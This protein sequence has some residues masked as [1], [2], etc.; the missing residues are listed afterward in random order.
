MNFRSLRRLINRE[1]QG[2]KSKRP[3]VLP[4]VE[5]LESRL[6]PSATIFSNLQL[7][8]PPLPPG[9][10]GKASIEFDAHVSL[11]VPGQPPANFDLTLKSPDITITDGTGKGSLQ[12]QKT[13][14]LQ[15]SGG[16]GTGAADPIYMKYD[17]LDGESTDKVKG[18]IQLLDFHFGGRTTFT[19][20][21][22]GVA[23]YTIRR[24]VTIQPSDGGIPIIVFLDEQTG[25]SQTDNAND[26]Q[27]LQLP[28]QFN[29]VVPLSPPGSNNVPEI[30][31]NLVI[32]DYSFLSNNN[33]P[34]AA[35]KDDLQASGM[36]SLTNFGLNSATVFAPGQEQENE[37]L[38]FQYQVYRDLLLRDVDDLQNPNGEV[39]HMLDLN[40][41]G[42]LPFL[43]I[44]T[45]IGL[46]PAQGQASDGS[47]LNFNGI[48]GHLD[49]HMYDSLHLGND[50]ATS[51]L[52]V[53]LDGIGNFHL[54]DLTILAPGL[55]QHEVQFDGTPTGSG[56]DFTL[57]EKIT[58]H[59]EGLYDATEKFEFQPP[60]S[61]SG[62]YI[63]KLTQPF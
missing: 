40:A 50:S 60:S 15:V 55:S 51:D 27:T 13:D 11:T 2:V 48:L 22:P 5:A 6:T 29:F 1:L 38:N 62:G 24:S 41:I 63:V 54:F 32:S 28:F 42:T 7:N 44:D 18:D 53:T 35:H 25:N 47:N 20:Q 8:P 46:D 49:L 9:F 36:G 43:R 33:Q 10:N 3:R 45:A 52:R 21:G 23:N 61:F 39:K 31:Y 19:Q 56:A 26:V 30:N 16:P 57:D 4:I 59:H 12:V 58:I 34:S 14:L 17:E 37:T